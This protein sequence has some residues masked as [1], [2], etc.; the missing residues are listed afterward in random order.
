MKANWSSDRKI[1]QDISPIEK[2]SNSSSRQPITV[3]MP[4]GIFF[5]SKNRSGDQRTIFKSSSLDP[6]MD[7]TKEPSKTMT[8]VSRS[9]I[10]LSGATT[11]LSRQVDPSVLSEK[12]QKP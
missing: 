3:D 12:K 8:K 1:I 11:G 4:L 7:E 5:I 6:T 10:S 9:V 2:T